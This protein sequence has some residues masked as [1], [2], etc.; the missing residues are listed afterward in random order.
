MKR[1]WIASA[2]LALLVVWA[3]WEGQSVSALMQDYSGQLSQAQELAKAERW[4][5]ARA[6]TERV[7]QNWREHELYL[8][9]QLRHNDVDNVLL[10]FREVEQYLLLEEM[11]QYAAANA[12]LIT[13][14]ELLG[15]MEQPTLVNI[16]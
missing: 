12:K 10:T 5:E 7:F 4:D 8:Y 3:L 2:L 13:Q 6:V 11:D 15:E 1:L 16:L 14:L 9:A